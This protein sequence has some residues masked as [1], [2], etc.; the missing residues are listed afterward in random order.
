MYT[1]ESLAFHA[2]SILDSFVFGICMYTS[3]LDKTYIY[4]EAYLALMT[5]M[6]SWIYSCFITYLK[7]FVLVFKIIIKLV[8]YFLIFGRVFN[9]V[10]IIFKSYF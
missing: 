7:D 2:N 5:F 10:K 8:A 9:Y 1:L 3:S 4:L 6:F